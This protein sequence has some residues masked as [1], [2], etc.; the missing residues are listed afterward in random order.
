M[1]LV[2]VRRFIW[3]LATKEARAL[4]SKAT[5]VMETLEKLAKVDNPSINLTQLSMIESRDVFAKTF[6]TVCNSFHTVCFY[7][8]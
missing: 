6:L 3:N 5:R 4:M 1:G 2:V 8:L 7:N